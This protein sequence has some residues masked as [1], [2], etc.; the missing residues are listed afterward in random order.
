MADDNTTEEEE[1]QDINVP[2]EMICRIYNHIF[3]SRR[4]RVQDQCENPFYY[5]KDDDDVPPILAKEKKVRK[6][7]NTK[8]RRLQALLLTQKPLC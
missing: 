7:Y 6:V 1:V 5:S 4:G 8:K 2:S 3:L